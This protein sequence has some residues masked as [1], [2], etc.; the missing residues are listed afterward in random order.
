MKTVLV[1]D[2][3]RI[4]RNIV[5]NTF[6]QLKIQVMFLEA[7]NG[8]SAVQVLLNNPVDLI[9][10]DWNM[11]QLSG[12]DFLRHVRSLDSYRTIPI[13]MVTSESS[14]L[15]VVE[16]IKAGATAY[17]TKPFTDKIFMDKLSKITF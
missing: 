1:V 10:L 17:I 8:I 11:P 13:I 12:I 6:D 5:K 9:L 4:M 2:D 15:N 14:K 7:N 16:A 3:S